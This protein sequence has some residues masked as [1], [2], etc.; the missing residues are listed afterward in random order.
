MTSA[1]QIRERIEAIPTGEPFT[2]VSLLA[3]GTRASVDQNLRRLVRSGHIVSVGR[4]VY[5]RPRMNRY[6]GA[7]MPE[8]YKIA[9]AVAHSTGAKIQVHGAEAARHF[10]LTTQVPTQPVYLTTGPTRHL[11]VGNMVVTLK[12][13]SP[14]KLSLPGRP[15]LAMAALLHLGKEGVTHE[16]I[17]TIRR[18]LEPEEFETLRRATGVMPGWLS[19]RFLRHRRATGLA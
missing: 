3:L 10:G 14:R 7:V 13:T 9:E 16:A 6:V 12:H 15:G 5:V 11:K 17:E 18:Q 2:T 8:P 4:G 19:D 1:E